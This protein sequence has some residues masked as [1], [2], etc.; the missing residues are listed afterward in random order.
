M[1][2]FI[3]AFDKNKIKISFNKS[4][5]KMGKFLSFLTVDVERSIKHLGCDN[6]WTKLCGDNGLEIKGGILTLGVW[7][8]HKS[9]EYLNSLK[10]GSNLDN[11]YNNFVN[12]FHLFPIMTDEGKKFFIDYYSEEIQAN[13]ESAKLKALYAANKLSN[14][15][16][17]Y[18]DLGLINP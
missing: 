3:K 16:K 13:I 6:G 12:P 7:P 8:S 14:M 9:V 18:S 15:T 10:Y 17:V 11:P 1:K 5:I 2:E 4:P